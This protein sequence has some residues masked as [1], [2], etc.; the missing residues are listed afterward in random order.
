MVE[1]AIFGAAILIFYAIVGYTRPLLALLTLPLMAFAVSCAAIGY[2]KVEYFFFACVLVLVTLVAVAI[3][4]RDPESQQ[5]FHQWAFWNLIVIAGVVAVG[6]MVMG[7]G[8]AGVGIV[9]PVF[10]FLGVTAAVASLI[11]YGI[12]SRNALVTHVFSTL[13][14]SVRQNLPLP[15][16]LDCAATGCERGMAWTLR[17]IKK[18]LVRGYPLVESLRRG[19]PQ[20]PAQALTML[21]AAERMGQLPAAMEAIEADAKL[22]SAERNRPRPVHPFYPLV[23]LSIMF[24]MMLFLLMSVVPQY[25]SILEEMAGGA[26]PSSTR[27]LVEITEFVAYEHD[28]VI[29]VSVFGLAFVVAPAFWLRGR[30]CQ[31]RP[32]RP[33]L[34]SRGV[35]WVKWHLP[36]LHWFERNRSTLQVVELLR[37]GAKAGCPV[38]EAIRGALELDVNLCFRKRLARWLEYVECGDNIADAARRCG[39]GTAL[40]WTFD[41]GTGTT[42]AP[43]LL[44][45]LE[46]FYRSN[47]SYRTNLA[48]FVVWP[49]AII[50]LGVTVGFVVYALFAPFVSVLEHMADYV[51]P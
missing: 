39:L 22:R 29:L 2:E 25:K 40:A 9:L 37:L 13:G 48:R 49:C 14:S 8:L 32:E 31:R 7:L 10:F 34:L 33:F 51:Y 18:W 1:M 45:M 5:W 23:V 20:C 19:Y 44:E 11:S 17:R 35:D 28:G 15:M 3:S 26:L 38:N 6:L 30:F 16:A 42:D 12:T 27:V 24:L 43:T 36:I 47:Y 41:E 50:V 46:S 4:E 21:S